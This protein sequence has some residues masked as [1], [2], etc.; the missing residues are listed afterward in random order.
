MWGHVNDAERVFL[1]RA[2]WFARRLI[3]HPQL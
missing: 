3:H 1:I 2:L